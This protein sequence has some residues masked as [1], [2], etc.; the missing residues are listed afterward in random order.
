M[1][2]AGNE[3]IVWASMSSD[4]LPTA[5]IDDLQR[6]AEIV[7]KLRTFFDDRGFF[8]VETPLLS[9]DTVVDRYIDPVSV[10]KIALTGCADDS[11]VRM[12]MQTSPEFSM[13]RLVVAGA[14]AIYQLSKCFRKGEKGAAHNPE[15]TMLEWYRVDDDLQSGMQLLA[16]LVEH[17]LQRPKTSFLSYREAF[18]QHANLDPFE[19]SIQEMKNV[20]Q[21]NEVV[22]VESGSGAEADSCDRDSWLNLILSEVIQQHLGNDHPVVVYDWPASQSALAIVRPGDFPVAERFEIYVDGVELA[23]GYHELLDP[24]ELARRSSI[25]N[26]GRLKDGN[27]LLPEDSRLLD[28]M[29]S[30][31]PQCAGVALGVDRLVM[32]ATGA[33][34][35]D[36]VVAFPIDRA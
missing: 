23:N 7:G 8:E 27:C 6:R 19:A 36:E 13:K 32:L 3:F 15:F 28:A 17:V 14:K 12:W 1:I 4:F 22:F 26:Q 18:L 16:E 11:D 29:R 21:E 34:T 10:P 2:S 30:G 35:I 5:S 24:D 33:A 31:L 25:N 20:L 9:H